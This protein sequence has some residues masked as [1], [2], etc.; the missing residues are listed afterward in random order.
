MNRQRVL[1]WL[2]I[3][4]WGGISS[5]LAQATD[6]VGSIQVSSRAKVQEDHRYLHGYDHRR[7][8]YRRQELRLL[9]FN[10]PENAP[11]NQA[12]CPVDSLRAPRPGLV[13]HLLQGLRI[14]RIKAIDPSR[15]QREYRYLDVLTDLARLQGISLDS[16]AHLPRDVL[17]WDRLEQI[18]LIVYERG[19]D[20]AQGAEYDRPTWL[21]LIWYDAQ[22]HRRVPL[23]VFDLR[24][25]GPWLSQLHC[26]WRD[27]QGRP[28]GT[29]AGRWLQAWT[30]RYPQVRLKAEHLTLLPADRRSL[31]QWPDFYR[32][33]P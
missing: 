2:F 25:I 18:M 31:D 24:V 26:R 6:S 28:T 12:F 21:Q 3:L 11:L 16:L 20:Q 9:D 17:Q 1:F 23:A 7:I 30:P 8:F 10:R 19:Y 33:Q 27:A 32:D 15:H 22:T 29:D 4:I 13:S 14:K 5:S